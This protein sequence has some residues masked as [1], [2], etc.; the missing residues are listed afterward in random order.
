M[1]VERSPSLDLLLLRAEHSVVLDGATDHPDAHLDASVPAVEV[2]VLLLADAI[3]LATAVWDASDGALPDVA[4][5]APPELTDAD[6]EKLAA[7]ELDVPVPVVPASDVVAR[8]R[9]HSKSAMTVPA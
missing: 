3:R 9:S 2:R 8:L 7:L 1:A 6:A 4:E 5:D